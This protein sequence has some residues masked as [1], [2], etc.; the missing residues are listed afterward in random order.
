MPA[1]RSAIESKSATPEEVAELL[2][3]HWLHAEG[4]EQAWRYSRLAGERARDLWANADAA[5]FFA[6]ALEAAS[7]LRRLPRATSSA[8]AEALG[9][10]CEL[11]ASYD[12]SRAALTHRRGDSARARSTGRGC[13]A[14]PACCMSARVATARRSPATREAAGSVASSTRCGWDRAG[15]AH[16]RLGG[17]PLAPGSLPGLHELCHRRRR[18]GGAG[19]APLRARPC[20]LP[21]AHDVGLP[22]RAGRR[23]RRIAPSPSPRSSVT[24]S[25]KAT[26]STTSASAPTTWGAG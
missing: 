9:D 8:V 3:L 2:S 18:R 17:H 6:R 7:R 11:T 22:G 1:P 26:C 10:A 23:S 21:R 16:A 25:D 24:S 15:R 20:A 13:C 5:T 19:R 12:R 4:Y 14:R